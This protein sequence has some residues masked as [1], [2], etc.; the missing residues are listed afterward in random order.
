[1]KIVFLLTENSSSFP[2][3]KVQ[4]HSSKFELDCV[5]VLFTLSPWP[6]G[7]WIWA[8]KGPGSGLT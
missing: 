3:D 8:G 2:G 1:M 7:C 6:S 5:H 4:E